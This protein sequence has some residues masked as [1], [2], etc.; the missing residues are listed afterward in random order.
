MRFTLQLQALDLRDL[1]EVRQIVELDDFE[2]IT[3]DGRE[4]GALPRKVSDPMWAW[5]RIG[6]GECELT[7][8]YKSYDAA[9]RARD[10]AFKAMRRLLAEERI[11]RECD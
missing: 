8:R 6:V 2:D 11:D 7:R 10:Q 9:F 1:I 5:R 4:L 3:F